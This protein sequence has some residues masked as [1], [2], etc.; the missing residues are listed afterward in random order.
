MALIGR[1]LG[2]KLFVPG[3]PICVQGGKLPAGFV[4][5]FTSSVPKSTSPAPS[6]AKGA[7]KL[8]FGVLLN[9]AMPAV[10]GPNVAPPSVDPFRPPFARTYTR[11]GLFG[12]M[13]VVAPSPEVALEPGRCQ[14]G[15]PLY[16]S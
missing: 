9:V 12:S 5:R 2:L 15:V 11:L 16:P 8:V 1:S 4:H 3:M 10:M 6:T 14:V 13:I 7:T